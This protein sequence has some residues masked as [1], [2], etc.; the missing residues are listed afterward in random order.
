MQEERAEFRADSTVALVILIFALSVMAVYLAVQAVRSPAVDTSGT[1]TR[2]LPRALEIDDK[3]PRKL[4]KIA[5]AVVCSYARPNESHAFR[6]RSSQAQYFLAL[7]SRLSSPDQ[8]GGGELLR[9][10]CLALDEE[11]LRAVEEWDAPPVLPESTWRSFDAIV[12]RECVED[13]P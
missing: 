8:R 11:Q 5:W 2:P 3:D 13:V 10:A 9:D 4:E 7:L 12:R 6:L 1:F